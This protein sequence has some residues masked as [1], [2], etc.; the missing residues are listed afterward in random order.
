MPEAA[1][2]P[3]DRADH[4]GL[5]SKCCHKQPSGVGVAV[6]GHRPPLPVPHRQIFGILARRRLSDGLPN[7][8]W[9]RVHHSMRGLGPYG[10]SDI[11]AVQP[12]MP[13]TRSSW[14]RRP[15]LTGASGRHAVGAT[16]SGTTIYAVARVAGVAISTASP[17]ESYRDRVSLT[18]AQHVRDAAETYG[19]H[20]SPP[21]TQYHLRSP[22]WPM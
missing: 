13:A 22:K 5:F 6:I 10:A 4:S 12:R 11:V 16:D 14:D 15:L 9:L 21:I 3:L 18:T 20:A 17:A 8:P 19:Y 2:E 7:P 1:R